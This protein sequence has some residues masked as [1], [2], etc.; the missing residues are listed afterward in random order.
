MTNTPSCGGLITPEMHAA[1]GRE[2][3]RM[4]SFPVAAS[5]IRRW[6]LAVYHPVAP[7]ERF[8]GLGS[9]NTAEAMAAPEDFN[10]FTWMVAEPQGHKPGYVPGA[11]TV[12]ARLG[13]AEVETAYMV[14]GGTEISYGQ[15]IRV[16][17]VITSVTT[18]SGY[19]D[20]LGTLGAMLFTETTATWTNQH[21][22]L[23]KSVTNTVIRY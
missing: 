2:L 22:E 19:T 11:P 14:N 6:A 18:L 12:E 20:R 4:V 7:P 9:S 16:G 17:D 21:H 5:D 15:P 3:G 10:P 8:W 1:V 23:V 13:L